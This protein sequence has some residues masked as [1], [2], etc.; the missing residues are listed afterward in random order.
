MKDESPIDMPVMSVTFATYHSLR[1]PMRDESPRDMHGLGSQSSN[2]ALGAKLLRSGPGKLH[3]P[4]FSSHGAAQSFIVK[5]FRDAAHF[6][7]VGRPLSKDSPS[8]ASSVSL[9]FLD[10]CPFCARWEVCTRDVKKPAKIR[11]CAVL[12]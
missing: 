12:P 1:L 7:H 8:I 5:P 9:I 2:V 4:S 6:V 11:C 3:F 10:R